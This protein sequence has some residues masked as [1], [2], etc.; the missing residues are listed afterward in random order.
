MEAGQLLRRQ[1]G[2]GKRLEIR[3]FR[4]QP[5]LYPAFNPSLVRGVFKG[6]GTEGQKEEVPPLIRG[7]V[8]D[9]LQVRDGGTDKSDIRRVFEERDI[10]LPVARAVASLGLEGK[11]KYF[12]GVRE[13]RVVVGEICNEVGVRQVDVHPVHSAPPTCSDIGVEAVIRALDTGRVGQI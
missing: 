8:S 3:E 13:R 4:L 11:R 12:V 1:G 2:E 10:H 7:E 5:L 6:D 9:P